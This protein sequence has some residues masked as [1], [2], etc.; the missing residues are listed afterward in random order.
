VQALFASDDGLFVA[1]VDGSELLDDD[2]DSLLLIFEVLQLLRGQGWLHG[3]SD[4]L[5][6]RSPWHY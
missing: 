6:N 4:G 3:K 2:F 1:F 5:L